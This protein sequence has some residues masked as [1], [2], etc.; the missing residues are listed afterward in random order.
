MTLAT[1]F[2]AL[3]LELA[4]EFGQAATLTRVVS[5]TITTGGTVT[6]T[7]TTHAVLVDG[8]VNEAKRYAAAGSDTRVTATF[9]L[10]ASGLTVTP[11]TP[12]RITIGTRKWQVVAVE[13]FQV[14]GTTTAYRLDCGEVA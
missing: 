6:Q 14:Q 3:E 4:T 5:A 7:T 2:L 9:Y 8:P 1:D 10:P 12:D 11:S 13:T